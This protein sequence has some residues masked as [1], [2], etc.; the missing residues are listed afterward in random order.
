MVRLTIQGRIVV[1]F[2]ILIKKAAKRK[3]KSHEKKDKKKKGPNKNYFQ[4]KVQR[5]RNNLIKLLY[6]LRDGYQYRATWFIS[7][8]YPD[9]F[10][11]EQ[12]APRIKADIDRLSKRLIYSYPDGWFIY[13]IEWKRLSGIHF[14][15]VGRKG[16]K[17]PNLKPNIE[18]WWLKI[19]EYKDPHLVESTYLKTLDDSNTRYGYLTK[20]EKMKGLAKLIKILGNSYTHGVINRKNLPISDHKKVILS[21]KEFKKFKRYFYNEIKKRERKMGKKSQS[22]QKAK[23]LYAETGFHIAHNKKI[24]E[25]LLRKILK[26]R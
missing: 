9:Y 24:F 5:R 26:S 6:G 14:H 17:R 13:S 18:K 11:D 20:R 19:V 8:I 12:I 4:S 25:E 7:L 3:N 2:A 23:L 1:W 21:G 10:S 15:L 16:K 22:I